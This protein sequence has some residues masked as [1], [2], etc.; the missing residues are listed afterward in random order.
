M[1][2]LRNERSKFLCHTFGFLIVGKL[3]SC[4]IR[5]LTGERHAKNTQSWMD[6]LEK[7]VSFAKDMMN[8]D[9]DVHWLIWPKKVDME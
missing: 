2:D 5:L 7:R 1:T 6:V 9:W 8:S 4:G 3:P